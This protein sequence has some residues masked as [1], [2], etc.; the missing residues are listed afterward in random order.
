MVGAYV[1]GDWGE[2]CS[3]R[4]ARVLIY[5]FREDRT[6]R[7]AALLKELP[8]RATQHRYRGVVLELS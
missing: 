8:D 2:D 1:G 7:L 4:S 5:A 3:F 6:E